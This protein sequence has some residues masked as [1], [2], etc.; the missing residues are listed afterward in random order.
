MRPES[1]PSQLDPRAGE[2]ADAGPLSGVVAGAAVPDTSMALTP[3]WLKLLFSEET[4]TVAEPATLV[5]VGGTKARTLKT[6]AAVVPPEV[7]TVRLR[8][9]GIATLE[10]ASVAVTWVSR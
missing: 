6:A 5:S 8:A 10:M 2:L 3:S 9:P 4:V 1:P 7:V